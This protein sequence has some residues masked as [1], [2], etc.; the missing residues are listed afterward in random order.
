MGQSKQAN[1]KHR[2]RWMGRQTPVVPHCCATAE[3]ATL[4]VTRRK[5]AGHY[6]HGASTAVP[7]PAVSVTDVMNFIP[8]ITEP[9]LTDSEN[10]SVHHLKNVHFLL[11]KFIKQIS[12]LYA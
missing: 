12:L 5:A 6:R 9:L 4:T 1:M 11:K 8:S 2:G 7:L 3:C 10:I